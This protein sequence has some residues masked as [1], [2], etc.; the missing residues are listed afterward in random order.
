MS[1]QSDTPRTGVL[2]PSEELKRLQRERDEA[3][4]ELALSEKNVGTYMAERNQ[5]RD[6][7]KRAR[8]A[9][10]AISEESDDEGARECASEALAATE[11]KP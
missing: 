8:A 3:R 5:A 9:L 10:R 11:P 4:A 1:D 6:V 2:V 7:V